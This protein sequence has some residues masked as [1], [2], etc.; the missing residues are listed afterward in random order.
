MTRKGPGLRGSAAPVLGR[1][2][3][4]PLLAAIPRSR[5]RPPDNDAAPPPSPRL[6]VERGE[7][8]CARARPGSLISS[9]LHFAQSPIAAV[10]VSTVRLQRR[11]RLRQ[12]V[13]HDT[14]RRP[15]ALVLHTRLHLLLL[16]HE[17]RR[18]PA[19]FGRGRHRR[20]AAVTIAQTAATR[21]STLAS[22]SRRASMKLGGLVSAN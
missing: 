9:P 2:L 7:R 22:R 15:A 5:V 6:G 11:R 16:R 14:A 20:R 12:P 4:R 18:R 19:R 10:V 21:F 13:R 17:R 3:F 1:L 8:F